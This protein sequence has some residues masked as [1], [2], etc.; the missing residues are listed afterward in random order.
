MLIYLGLEIPVL[1]C[2]VF[3]MFEGSEIVIADSCCLQK[4]HVENSRLTLK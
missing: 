2:T 4:Q 1:L 3:H